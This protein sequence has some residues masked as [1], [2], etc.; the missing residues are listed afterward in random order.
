MRLEITFTSDISVTYAGFDLTYELYSTSSEGMTIPCPGPSIC[1]YNGACQS[2]ACSCLSGYVGEDCSNPIICP[3]NLTECGDSCDP[4]C[5]MAQSNVIAVS[6]FGDDDQ[7]TG[8]IMDT[9]P[10]G[11]S[12]KAVK[13][14]SRALE[15]ADTNQ[16]I[17][18]YPGTFTGQP[19]CNAVVTIQGVTIRGL[20]GSSISIL[21]CASQLNAI[22]VF[23]AQLVKIVDL[24]IQNTKGIN[25]SAIKAIDSSIQISGTIVM[26]STATQFGGGI[27]AFRS[28]VAL[29]DTKITNCMALKAGG[30]YADSSVIV[31]NGS[32][33]SSCR[34]L[35]GAGMYVR[36]VSL[37][38]GIG[39]SSIE[40]N[41]A[42]NRGGGIFTSET[43]TMNSFIIQLNGAAIGGGLAIENGATS[44]TN[45]QVAFNNASIDG[46]GIGLLKSGTFTAATSNITSNL[47][48]RNG[49]GLYVISNETVAFDSSSMIVN[50]SA[51]KIYVSSVGLNLTLI[52]SL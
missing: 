18:L 37:V 22:T 47:A 19:N 28:T 26:N 25:G 49:G 36:G 12:S 17:L 4:V 51:G 3:Y 9:S 16:T 10:T 24:T 41:I 31:L 23:N 21:D 48:L 15:I 13:S 42:S 39:N 46:G 45:V 34:A 38:T 7:G 32:L 52:Y 43:V 6:L 11:T 27:Y 5:F 44:V 14:I 1:S 30:I 20:R 8:E 33:V 50:C 40:T 35:D 2:G 29:Q